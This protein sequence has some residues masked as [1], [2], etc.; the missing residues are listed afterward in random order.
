[1]QI[2]LSQNAKSMRINPVRY[3]EWRDPHAKKATSCEACEGD[4]KTHLKLRKRREGQYHACKQVG[5]ALTIRAV[6]TEAG[7]SPREMIWRNGS[8]VYRASWL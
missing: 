1:M 3:S 5:E 6:E 7:T 8:Q 2:V 4:T